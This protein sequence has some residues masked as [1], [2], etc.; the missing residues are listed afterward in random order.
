MRDLERLIRE[1]RW[2]ELRDSL[3]KL[4]PPDVASVLIEVPDVKRGDLPDLAA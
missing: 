2:T 4:A 1:K 3:S